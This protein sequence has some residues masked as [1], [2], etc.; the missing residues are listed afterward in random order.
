LSKN[1]FVVN[2]IFLAYIRTLFFCK[3]MKNNLKNNLVIGMIIGLVALASCSKDEINE[4]D[5]NIS[6]FEPQQGTAI[7][8]GKEL[9]NPYS[10]SNMEKALANLQKNAR[11]T[12]GLTITTTHYY[13]R[14]LPKDTSDVNKLD[15]DTTLVL[16]DYPL[17]Y[18]VEEI[19]NWY[20]DPTLADNVPTWQYT[21]VKA[22]YSFPDVKY[23]IL[24]DLFMLED[25]D[26]TYSS[27]VNKGLW[28]D[29]EWEAM[30]ITNNLPDNNT[31][32]RN[33]MGKW[34]PSGKIMVE[35]RTGNIDRGD[36]PVRYCRVRARRLLKWDSDNTG[37]ND[38]EF[39]MTK[40]FRGDVNYSLEFETAGHKVTNS[41]GFSI[42]LNGPKSGSAW[43]LNIP[44]ANESEPWNCATILNAIYHFRVQANTHRIK[45]PGVLVTVKVRP[46]YKE[47]RSHALGVS[48]HIP[49]IATQILSQNDVKIYTRFRNTGNRLQTD[50]L[51]SLTMHEL[52]HV[53]HFLKSPTNAILS[54]GIVNESWAQAV[55]YYFTRPYY[56]DRVGR[57]PDQSRADIIGDGGDDWQYTPFFIDLIDNTNQRDGNANSLQWANDNVRGYTLEQ[58]QTALNWRTNLDGITN[59]LKEKNTNSTSAGLNDV[60][61]FYDDIRKN[62]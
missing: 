4:I 56:P 8:L 42:N 37:V 24:S 52:G 48:R 43:N 50:H 62:H 58:I 53:S 1:I 32:E 13:V 54:L 5:T 25:N 30:R 35:E 23:E 29:L 12:D 18:E 57:I 55:E 41:I 38:G 21:V 7:V 51:Y 31:A 16:F 17:L 34:H 59:H 20:H 61:I 60:F 9:E 11:N 47:G 39:R 22:D 46:V 6:E 40:D 36:V 33:A 10:V 28:D 44:F 26:E 45:L 27:R 3:R 14:F 2:D 19:G 15:K 49:I